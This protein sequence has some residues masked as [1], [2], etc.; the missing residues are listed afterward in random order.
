MSPEFGG[1]HI[2][3]GVG[4]ILHQQEKMS[5]IESLESLEYL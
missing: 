4:P 3:G 1:A 5:M 2:G